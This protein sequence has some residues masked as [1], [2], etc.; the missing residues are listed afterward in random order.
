MFNNNVAQTYNFQDASQEIIIMLLGAF[1]LG[2]LLT[3]LLSKLLNKDYSHENSA[4]RYEHQGNDEINTLSQTPASQAATTSDVRIVDKPTNPIKTEPIPD[5]LTKISGVDTEMQNKLKKIGVTSFANLSDFKTK[6]LIAFQEKQTT[7]KREIDTWPHQASLAAKGEWSKLTDYQGFIHRVQAASKTA[8][9]VRPTDADD[10]TKLIGINPEIEGTL[11]GKEIYTFKQ[12]SHLDN[13]TLK[14]Y[15]TESDS[16]LVE[17]ETESWPHQAAMAEKGQWDE[18]KI[19]QNF[20]DS[21]SEIVN[22]SKI[23]SVSKDSKIEANDNSEKTK[24]SSN[25]TNIDSKKERNIDKE[26]SDTNLSDHDDLKKIEG[27]G[28]KI[29]EVLNNG[30][31]YT[32][33]QLYKSDRTRL[34]KLLDDAGNQFRMHD[35]ESWPHQA[36]MA[37]RS[38]WD[39]L[40]TYQVS[41]NKEQKLSSVKSKKTGT[42]K[43]NKSAT[44]KVKKSTLDLI[45]DDLRKIEGIGPKIQELLNNAGIE[46][47]QQLSENSRDHIKNL[48]NEAGPQFRMHEP[49]SWPHQ[50]KLAAK[51]KWKELAEYQD[52]L[53]TGRE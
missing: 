18:L 19:Y 26:I 37:N 51:G 35:P 48:L 34:R 42:E 22:D 38:E 7:N 20:M 44:K 45:K 41:I 10:L 47:F 24:V 49:E 40:K 23:E 3:W 15:I 17:S 50:A 8:G 36:G 32:F 12:L 25:I 31:I 29:E 52:F 13:D 9:K 2:A 6:D 1:L 4:Y 11:N 46:S 14:T 53:I 5:D 21:D 16:L 43:V 27:I 33:S 30:G 28:P 39:E